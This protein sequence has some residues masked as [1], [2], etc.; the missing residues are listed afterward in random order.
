[1]DHDLRNSLTRRHMADCLQSIIR[2]G[3]ISSS[4][5]SQCSRVRPRLQIPT[6]KPR[7][8]RRRDPFFDFLLPSLRKVGQTS[9]FVKGTPIL[10]SALMRRHT[11]ECTS[12]RH[13]WSLPCNRSRRL[14]IDTPK[15][16]SP[17]IK[18]LSARRS[19]LTFRSVLDK[20]RLLEKP[21]MS[22]SKAIKGKHF[23][24]ILST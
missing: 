9:K 14:R 13:H 24:L 6:T 18:P 5:S 20:F 12:R 2:H 19:R 22:L 3:V 1:M 8:L 23:N 7:I 10:L 11:T 21:K 15:I 17:L 4:P 16:A